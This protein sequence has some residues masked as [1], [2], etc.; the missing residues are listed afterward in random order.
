MTNAS[1]EAAELIATR[2]RHGRRTVAVA[3]TGEAGPEPAGAAAVGTVWCAIFDGG[4]VDSWRLDLVSD[5]PTEPQQIV[6][7]TV[8]RVLSDVAARLQPGAADQ[9]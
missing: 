5:P 8:D 4:A 7:R 1:A 9:S 2:A 3:V 6:A